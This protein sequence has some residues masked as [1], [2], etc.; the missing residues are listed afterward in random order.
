MGGQGRRGKEGEW[1]KGEEGRNISLYLHQVNPC[2]CSL[3]QKLEYQPRPHS[4]SL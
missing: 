1:E 2:D 3:P 4:H